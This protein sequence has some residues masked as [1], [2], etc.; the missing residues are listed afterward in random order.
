MTTTTS[1][2]NEF[3]YSIYQYDSLYNTAAT[4]NVTAYNERQATRK[5][6]KTDYE[7]SSLIPSHVETNYIK[8]NNWK[9]K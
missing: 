8:R 3:K 4:A 5:I 1:F 7:G 2:V 9:R 6:G